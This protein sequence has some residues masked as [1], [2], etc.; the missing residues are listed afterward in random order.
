LRFGTPFAVEPALEEALMT[1]TLGYSS[2]DGQALAG[3]IMWV[4][5]FPL[6]LSILRLIVELCTSRGEVV[7]THG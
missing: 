5:S 2:L 4:G 6:L 7:P 3:V 1:F